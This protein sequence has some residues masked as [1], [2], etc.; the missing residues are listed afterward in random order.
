MSLA[1]RPGIDRV[2]VANQPE[3]ARFDDLL[4]GPRGSG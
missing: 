3:Q 4:S 1:E 2:A